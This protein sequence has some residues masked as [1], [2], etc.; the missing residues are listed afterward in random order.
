MLS[1][2]DGCQPPSSN[3]LL[4]FYANSIRLDAVPLPRDP[5]VRPKR[6]S[7]Q[8]FLAKAP[9]NLDVAID[10]GEITEHHWMTPA[11]ALLRRSAG[12]IEMVTPTFCTLNWL[13]L[14]ACPS[15]AWPCLLP[16]RLMSTDTF[17]DSRVVVPFLIFILFSSLLSTISKFVFVKLF[18]CEPFFELV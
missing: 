9:D 14:L 17:F 10:H 7:T 8:F 2:Y 12:E 3:E 13:L 1:A 11:E 5:A 4:A 18:L 16:W 6:F 15:I